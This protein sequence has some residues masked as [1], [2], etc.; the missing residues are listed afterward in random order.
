M[1]LEDGVE[2]QPVSRIWIGAGE[3]GLSHAGDRLQFVNPRLKKC[4]LIFLFG[5]GRASDQGV[6]LSL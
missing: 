2:R 4:L 1:D 5:G 6:Q 3:T